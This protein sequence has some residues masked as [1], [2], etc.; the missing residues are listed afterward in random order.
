MVPLSGNFRVISV[1]SGHRG[2][3]RIGL[4]SAKCCHSVATAGFSAA[5]SCCQSDVCAERKYGTKVF[6][7]RSIGLTANVS[8]IE[9]P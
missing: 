8:R 9:A 2:W 5:P 3:P 4:F 6:I 7:A 1:F